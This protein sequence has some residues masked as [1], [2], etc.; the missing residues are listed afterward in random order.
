MRSG[1]VSASGIIVLSAHTF[2][3]GSLIDRYAG[4]SMLI[5]VR[6][7]RVLHS[8]AERREPVRFSTE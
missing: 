8:S 2:E 6:R 4:A 3:G 7:V 5:L 1:R